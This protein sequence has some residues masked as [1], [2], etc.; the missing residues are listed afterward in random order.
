M[1]AHVYLEQGVHRPEALARERA[2]DLHP[3]RRP[4]VLARRGRVRG[5]RRL[6]GRGAAHSLAP[7]AHG[8][9]A[10]G[11][12][13]RRHLLPAAAGL[14]RRV[15]RLPPSQVKLGLEGRRALVTGGSKGIG[16]AIARELVGEGVRVA[17]CARN[18]DEVLAA[19]EELRRRPRAA[20]RRHRSRAGSR[21][22]RAL[23]R[24]A[25]RDRLPRQQRRR[26]APRHLRDARRTRTGSPTSTSSSS[27]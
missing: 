5:R 10:R 12:A 8:G 26:R 24:G 13:G 3:R 23:R 9:G 21:F 17:I 15:R 27:R 11:H 25:R 1:L 16:A 2:A 14:A 19:A 18:E 22:R 20:G 7:P 4:A 6:R